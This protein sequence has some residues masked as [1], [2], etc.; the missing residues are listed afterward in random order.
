MPNLYGDGIRKELQNMANSFSI[1]DLYQ[2]DELSA[3]KERYKKA[4]EGFRNYYG[5]LNDNVR[6]FSAPGRTEV[7][8]N[9]T[10]HNH[11]KVLAAS[12]NL[13]VIAVVEPLEISKILL[14]SEGFTES[15][16]D[17]NDTEVKEQEKNTADA[18]IRGVVAGFKKNG[19]NVGGFKAYTT[20][21]VLKGSGL[22]SSAAF[23]VLVGNI[24]N[25]LYNKGVVTPIKIAQIAQYAENEYFG[26]PSGLMD[27]MASSVG[28]FV[29]IDFKD[30]ASPIIDKI[31]LDFS[32][33]NH[34]LCIVDTKGSHADLTP[35]YAAIPEEMKA[36]ANHFSVDYL[37]QICRADIMLNIKPLREEFGDRAVLRALHFF[38]ENYRVDKLVHALR[39][40]DFPAFLDSIRESGN[41]SY[42][43]LQNV[44]SVNDYKNQGLGI[45]LNV[46]EN[47]LN[48]KGAC[49]V[50][51]G[52]FAGTIQAFVPND[53]LKEFKMDL[54]KVF[55]GGSCH[56]LG[57]RKVGGC[58]V[59][60]R[61]I[62]NEQWTIDNC[63]IACGDD[64]K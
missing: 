38:D 64:L 35:D 26:K 18:L 2:P 43:Y 40:N 52:G 22:S 37:R 17:T 28:G 15:V 13:D 56:V 49:R 29:A 30:T 6:L 9:H 23:E 10:D 60:K 57:I 24:L 11:G 47:V 63:G 36:I 32:Q 8:G 61:T 51:G 44:F 3:Q 50:H 34:A 33:F 55:G 31:E 21:N 46:A 19:Y 42:K 4:M 12:V 62:D 54:E 16:I 27:Q 25:S 5:M 58:E 7:G 1:A 45:G 59:E 53:L 20:T 41:S 39:S 14:K 48:R